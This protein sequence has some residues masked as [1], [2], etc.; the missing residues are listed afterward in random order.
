[1]LQPPGTEAHRG[2]PRRIEG[3]RGT[4]RDGDVVTTGLP[5]AAEP[6]FY[7]FRAS[8]AQHRMYFLQQL[9]GDAP[10][11]HLPIFHRLEGAV[12][13][14][15]L[16][17]AAEALVQRHEALRTTFA[18]REGELFQLISP[19]ADFAWQE[20]DVRDAEDPEAAA[21]AWIRDEAARPFDLAEGPLFRAGLL[22]VGDRDSVLLLG[23]HHIVAD[24]WSTEILLREFTAT[25]TALVDGEETADPGEPDFQYAD[26]SSW[27]DEW[28][29]S[30]QAKRQREHWEAELAGELPVLRLP[31]TRARSAQAPAGQEAQAAAG[32]EADTPAPRG[33]GADLAFPLPEAARQ[34]RGLCAG[35]NATFF[36]G[37]LAT[38][39]ILLN[40]YTGLD[41]IVVGTPIA[42]RHRDE[43]ADTVGLF[44]NTTVFRADLSADPTFREL[45]GQVRD[46]VL[47][48]QG[49][50]DLP[51]EEL[52]RLK[53]PDR[54][55]DASPLFQV[56]FGM[57]ETGDE[58]LRLPG[59]T[60]R[61]VPVDTGT[62]KFDLTLDVAETPD[63]GASGV[64]E[65]RT[66]LFD[67]RIV[68]ALAEHYGRLIEEIVAH[69]DAP[70]SSLR[71]LSDAQYAEL[72]P[73][74][75]APGRAETPPEP[76]HERFARWAAR[77]PD[78]V[79]LV[80]GDT[81]IG[82]AELDARADR[83]ARRLRAHG[84]GPGTLVGLSMERSA[85]LVTGLL[86]VLKAGGAYVPLDPAYPVE[87]LRHMVEDSGLGTILT[88]GGVPRWWEGFDGNVLD[89]DDATEDATADATVKD[90]AGPPPG[91][92]GPDDLAYVIYTSGSTGRPKG[93]L[94]P[95]RNIS[96]LFTSTDR[97]FGFDERD[98][99]TLFHSYAFD[100]SVWELW[101]ALAH[102][103][104][105]VIVPYETSREPAA[106]LRLLREQ[107]VTVLNQ[108]PSAFYQ[109]I[110]AEETEAAEETEGAPAGQLALRQVIF[111]GEALDPHALRDW[112]ARHGDVTP[113]LVNM[114][115][116]TETTVHVTY[117]PITLE[118]L[119]AGAGSVIGEPIDDLQL[120]VLDRHGRPVPPGVTGELYVGGRGL[121]DGYLNR[122]ELTAERF[123]PHPFAPV[124]AT[125]SVPGA[126][127]RLYRTG[128]LARRLPDGDLEYGGRIDSQI[129][130]RGFRVE[131]GEVESALTEH[132][133]AHEAVVVL[134]TDADGHATLAAYV[135]ARG[136]DLDPEALRG[137][138]AHRLPG[139]MIPS[140]FTVLPEFPLTANGKVDRAKLPEPAPRAASHEGAFTAPATAAEETLASVWAR[141]L[142]VERVGVDDNYFALGGDSIRSIRLLS[143]AREAGLE[144]GFTDLMTHQTV[145]TLAAV[146][147]T[148]DRSGDESGC[149][150]FSLLSAADR[151]RVPDGVTDAYPMTR[152]QGGMLFHSDLSGTG[153]E[154]HNVSTYRL[155]AGFCER[156][157]RE[158]VAGLLRRHEILRTSFDLGRFD[159]PM[160]LVWGRVPLPLTFEDLRGL[161]GAERDTA[162]DRRFERERAALFDPLT[163]PLIRFHVQRLTDD[164]LQ[165]FISEHHAIL[166]GWSERSLFA[167]LLLGYGRGLSGAVPETA[168]PPAARFAS[169]VRLEREAIADEESRRFW[170][171]QLAGSTLTRLPGTPA[172]APEQARPVMEIDERPVPDAVH[173]GLTALARDL[174]V[175]LRTVLLAAH[176]RVLSLLTGTE[177]VVT[178]AV[179]GGRSEER[180]GDVALGVFLNTLPVRARL[181]G[182]TWA[183]LVRAT[184]EADLAIQ[185]HRRFPLSEIVREAGTSE[186][187][188]AFFNYTHFHVEASVSEGPEASAGSPVRVLDERGIAH[189]NFPFGAEFFRDGTDGA[190]GLG[191]RHDAARFGAESVERAHG[192][193]AAA[194]AALATDPEA[195]YESADLLSP[196]EHRALAEA[197]ATAEVFDR[198]H[199][200]HTL[201]EE[202]ARH[203]PDAPAVR[204]D[205]RTLTYRELDARADRL[206]D[207]LRA[208]GAGPGRFVAVLV[209][210][211]LEL[212]V[213]LLAVLKSGAAYVPLDPDHPEQR[214]RG[215]LDDAGISLVISAAPWDA[216]VAGPGIE[217]VLPEESGKFEE[218]GEPREPGDTAPGGS[219]GAPSGP[220]DP[221][222]M[223]F[224][225]GSTGKPK[226]VVVSHRAIANRLLWMQ[227]AYGL[228]PGEPVLHKTPTTFDVSV[229]ELFWPLLA[230][231]VLVVAKPGGHRDPAYLAGLIEAES[232]TT[233][234]FV[235]SMLQAFVEDPA[236]AG[237]T[238]LTR[239]VCSGEALPY[240]LQERFLARFPAE[241]HNLYGPT[242]AAVDVTHWTCVD[243]GS[244]IVPIG[245]PVANTELHVLDRHGLPVPQG[246]TG[247]LYLGGVQLAEGY[248][249]RPDLTGASFVRHTDAHG[250]TRRLYRTGD[251]VRRLPGGALE[252]RGRT[253]AQI[254]LR[255]FRIELGE[256][257]AVLSAHTSVAECAVLLREE[258]LAAY[259][260]PAP[261][262]A[263]EPAALAAH[264]AAALPAYMV[265]T[266][267]SPLAAM[268]L[269]NSG[270]LDRKRLPDPAGPLPRERTAAPPRDAREKRL[271]EIW[272]ELLGRD[273]L[274]IHDDFFEAGGHSLL[275]LRLISRI[276]AAYGT[277][278]GVS[279]VLAHPT[280]A[281]QAALLRDG[282]GAD[283]RPGA[284]VPLAGGG[285]QPPLFLVH[286]VGGG[287]LC[288]REA[289]AALGTGRPVHGLPAPGLTPGTPPPATVRE[290][291]DLGL[292]AVREVQPAGPYRLSGWSFG[293]LVAYEMAH[294]LTG[295]G[296][297]VELLALLDT[298]FPGT[299]G[300][301][302]TL[303]ADFAEDLLRSAG[304]SLPEPLAASLAVAQAAGDEEAGLRAVRDELSRQGAGAGL[305]LG[306]L[307][308]HYAVFRANT[309]AAAAYRPPAHRGA[310]HFYQS[311]DGARLGSARAW[312]QAARG[313]LVVRDLDTD[314][315]GIV[316]GAHI[317]ET[318]KDMEKIMGEGLNR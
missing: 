242:E 250:V 70:V 283:G 117:R 46:R 266:A 275:A 297:A 281:R 57:N 137:H 221:A 192:Y 53:N 22:R 28:L 94:V 167:E 280:A 223:I 230:G 179:L 80:D 225:S 47:A 184:A 210:R 188:E 142:G 49:Q 291:A 141:A 111:G 207:R 158:A 154:Y 64:F 274:G 178:G 5:G 269:T 116:I 143:L 112:F 84:V 160:Q 260:V 174:G 161:T 42:G 17:G 232:V 204:Y 168:P 258:R 16:R 140:T 305:T 34:L 120:Y 77:T 9:A 52:V 69:P 301:P 82:Y 310:V 107:R 181:T 108:T 132:E 205:G 101:G 243:D 257:E 30:P 128:D 256:I 215:I 306:E 71:M 247:E 157:W 206:A 226:G 44:I 89:A 123:V 155:A 144:I 76:V 110:R 245:R 21:G 255:G 289:A 92:A 118:D 133:A 312:A 164:T 48:A 216:K 150:P 67:A 162:A 196:A 287:V 259:Y 197:N 217:V 148:A 147:R 211:S 304:L 24:G 95:H 263:P 286:P 244:G 279:A 127:E 213:L 294:T 240:D 208:R 172:A 11:Y 103:G 129:Q 239:V 56:M 149:P 60:A 59:I 278:L 315:Y 170:A 302:E 159:E 29:D 235:P 295:Q 83:L 75:R 212:P 2:S 135:T 104:R 19:E 14:R 303:L 234:H 13:G 175:P 182:G 114:Y 126:G 220:A 85:A 252:Y 90:P 61:P 87:R 214:L 284:A 237:C 41:D 314:H 218:S 224:T 238:G 54:T 36:M 233:A 318:A 134:H 119:R 251:L 138:A 300:A 203:T 58:E 113:R 55:A 183:D 100:F 292:R 200:L 270:K 33:A 165:L 72:A 51:F 299:G 228:R 45:L 180:D 121:A 195:R 68:G 50:Q 288:Y 313:P 272:S 4:S 268:P 186:L 7:E 105:L 66:D 130:L 273:G 139:Y 124:P 231:G 177:D 122:P 86:A 15:A 102:G 187:F 253:D 93:V 236:T 254:K 241:L 39:D 267:W 78:A 271:L 261:G 65:Y 1:M 74:P 115:G 35:E 152:L 32:Q 136:A 171:D 285:G 317:R 190:L 316:R 12:D 169:Y 219:A 20:C 209:E 201:V 81:T 277:G 91:G 151:A 25:Y 249:R 99:W 311:T 8:R 26:Y 153:T 309:L 173:R 248:H 290:L 38:F 282:L 166:D 27:Q 31:A 307:A 145:R 246:V 6:E 96:R 10:T 79:A 88:G 227:R 264:L 298:G 3:H 18:A 229:W 106:F 189:T 202:Q 265:P 37:L 176:L 308:R 156:S 62:A 262:P 40:C 276:N 193:Y 163:A 199:V 185:R 191:L 125:G 73:P 222:Y 98:V 43:F 198:P 109:L 296:E 23:M 131:L 293:G 63:G 97:W 146:A 194:L